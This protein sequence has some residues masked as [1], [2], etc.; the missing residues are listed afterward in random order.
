MDVA[1]YAT[2]PDGARIAYCAWRPH[3]AR[4][5]LVLLHGVASNATRWSEFVAGT[6]LRADWALLRM[7]LRGQG[8]SPWHG[9]IGMADWCGDLAA[10]LDAEG[11]GRAI[12]GGHCLGA[13]IA[14]EFACRHPERTA[15]LVLIEPMPRQALTGTMRQLA[16]LRR[17]HPRRRA[18]CAAPRM[19]PAAPAVRASLI[20]RRSTGRRAR[21]RARSGRRAQLRTL[22][23]P[24]DT[25]GQ[26]QAAS[27]AGAGRVTGRLPDFGAMRAPASY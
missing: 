14:L 23:V 2:A 22:C 9:R 4:G 27:T 7:D 25:R 20:S 26:P 8:R 11:F 3:A 1:K 19:W 5:A 13:N 12:V 6:G 24:L 21:A 16:R 15:G 17:A 18:R 10:M